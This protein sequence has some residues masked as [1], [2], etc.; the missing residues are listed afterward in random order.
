MACGFDCSLDHTLESLGALEQ[1]KKRTEDMVYCV[2]DSKHNRIA[3]NFV[4]GILAEKTSSS[5]GKKKEEI[6]YQQEKRFLYSFFNL[7]LCQLRS[8]LI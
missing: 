7:V 6:S 3:G 1:R 5:K 4:S 8:L 2:C